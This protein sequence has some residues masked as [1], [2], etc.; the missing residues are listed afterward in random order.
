[1]NDII[2]PIQIDASPSILIPKT[3]GLLAT[4]AVDFCV[5]QLHEMYYVY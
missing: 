1:M 5:W 3:F 2:C 4:I